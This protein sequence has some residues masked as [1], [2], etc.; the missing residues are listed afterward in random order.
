MTP[1]L[2]SCP[3]PTQPGMHLEP[4]Q[5]E[6]FRARREKAIWESV[7][8]LGWEIGLFLGSLAPLPKGLLRCLGRM[9]SF[10]ASPA[11]CFILITPSS[12]VLPT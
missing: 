9:A 6:Q 11:P 8:N 10:L 1:Y 5:E 2:E 3:T 4:P 12:R 7:P